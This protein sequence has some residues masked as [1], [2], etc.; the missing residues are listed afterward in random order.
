KKG[1]AG[2]FDPEEVEVPEAVIAEAME[3]DA[4]IQALQRDLRNKLGTLRALREGHP[5]RAIIQ[6]EVDHLEADLKIK[7]DELKPKL[8]AEVRE[9]VGVQ[10]RD[11]LK[12][13]TAELRSREQ[14]AELLRK[15]IDE[16][17]KEQMGQGDKSLELQFAKDELHNVEN[18]HKQL[19][20]R[21]VHLQTEG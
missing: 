17:R 11:A 13:A 2:G 3:K 9:R 14:Q 1:L 16:E 4:G 10:R 18:V 19:S 8:E 6:A 15:R 20:D 12:Q 21:I 5:K 7:K